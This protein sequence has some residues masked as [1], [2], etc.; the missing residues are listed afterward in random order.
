[1]K[2]VEG[3]VSSTIDDK[4]DSPKYITL[5]SFGVKPE[6]DVFKGWLETPETALEL[7]DVHFNQYINKANTVYWRR[8]P[9]VIPRPFFNAENLERYPTDK[10]IPEDTETLMYVAYCRLYAE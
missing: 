6:G 3:A 7:L 5:T 4:A 8:K 9:T 2:E 1:M 10:M